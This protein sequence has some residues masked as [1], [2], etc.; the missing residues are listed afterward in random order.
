MRR[1]KWPPRPAFLNVNELA[2]RYGVCVATIRNWARAGILPQ[3][4]RLTAGCSRW[5]LADLEAWEAERRKSSGMSR[6]EYEDQQR[7]LRQ[8]G[9][10]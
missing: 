1:T 6:Q 2:V 8:E 4:T 7:Q 9:A 3:P 10:T 5:P